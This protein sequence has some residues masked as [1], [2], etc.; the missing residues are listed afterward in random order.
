MQLSAH[1]IFDGQCEA[2]FHFYERVLGAKIVFLLRYGDSPMAEQTP[3]ASRSKV[4]HAT[5]QIG[6]QSLAGADV[7]PDQYER[8]Q[9]FYLL[10]SPSDPVLAEKVFTALADQGTVRMPLQKTF[11]SPAYGVLVDR[12]GIPWEISCE[13]PSDEGA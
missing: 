11:W 9:G 2:A 3:P 6:G 7:L 5:L 8:P 4:I 1:L 10:L 12:F 13:N